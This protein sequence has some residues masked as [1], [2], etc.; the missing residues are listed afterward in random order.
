MAVEEVILWGMKI[1]VLKSINNSGT[2]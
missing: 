1:G 2:F